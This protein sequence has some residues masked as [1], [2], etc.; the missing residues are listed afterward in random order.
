MKL[1]D[2]QIVVFF[3]DSITKANLGS[4]YINALKK[5]FAE[6]SIDNRF[7]FVNAGRDGDM[8]DDLVRRVEDD[9]LTLGP[10]WVVVLVG[11]NDV[12]YES[13]IMTRLS[14][15]GPDRRSHAYRHLVEHFKSNYTSLIDAIRGDIQNV[16]LCTTTSVEG[17][18]SA[19]IVEKLALVN[20]AIRDLAEAKGCQLIDVNRAFKSRL[21][22]LVEEEPNK[23]FHLTA[24]GVHLN[25]HGA[26]VVAETLFEFFMN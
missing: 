16:A 13:I 21:E 15:E 17:A 20:D 11:I 6:H 14:M 1:D 8:V 5:L 18:L 24:D 23:E 22:K 12:F 19:D 10:D 9:V 2:E 25:K 7:D 4:N 3:G 26:Q